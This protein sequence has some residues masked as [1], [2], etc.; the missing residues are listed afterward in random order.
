MAKRDI[1]LI[2]IPPLKARRRELRNNPTAAE[3]ILWKHLQRRQL[4]GKKFRRQYSIGRYIV[5][6]FCFEYDLAVEL[7][8]A[9]HFR[10][11]GAKYEGE[12]TAFL[13]GVGIELI[14]FENKIVYENIEAVLET[15]REAIRRRSGV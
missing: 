2:N 9:P 11:L 8:G 3:A 1:N 14:R 6:F 7:D 12:R 15:I 5:D 10:E 4:L 13:Q